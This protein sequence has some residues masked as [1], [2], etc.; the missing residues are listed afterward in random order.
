MNSS[1]REFARHALGL[2]N[3]K[4]TSYRN[5]YCIGSHNPAHAEWESLVAVGD[6]VKRTGPHWG[7]DDMFH[8]TLPGALKARDT[9]EH[10]SRKDAEQMRKL[11]S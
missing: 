5:H 10:I 2:P 8:L 1:Q 4:H 6:A 9:K 3:K 7:G 11:T